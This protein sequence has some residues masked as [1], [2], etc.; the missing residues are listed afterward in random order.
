MNVASGLLCLQLVIFPGSLSIPMSRPICHRSRDKLWG[1]GN[2]RRWETPEDEKKRGT[3]HREM[4]YGGGVGALADERWGWEEEALQGFLFL[5]ARRDTH[6]SCW[7]SFTG[8]RP[9]GPRLPP[10]HMTS[11]IFFLWQRD[12]PGWCSRSIWPMNSGDFVHFC[13]LVISEWPP[14]WTLLTADWNR[15]R[16]LSVLC[17]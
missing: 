11:M 14:M 10:A 6:S 13:S 1:R 17:T 15:K 16:R 7:I 12:T 8:K 9:P 5:E 3:D 4:T 2:R